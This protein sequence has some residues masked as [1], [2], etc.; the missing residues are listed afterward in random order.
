MNSPFDLYRA[1]LNGQVDVNNP[2]QVRTE[3]KLIPE[4]RTL[5]SLQEVLGQQITFDGDA[6]FVITRLSANSTGVFRFR[7]G[8]NEGHWYIGAGRNSGSSQNRVRS[9]NLFGTA[10]LP[11]LLPVPIVIPPNGNIIYDIQDISAA[12]NAIELAFVGYKIYAIQ[13]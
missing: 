9:E 5:T 7:L 12:E 1:Y 10:A 8:D 4:N 6:P 11:F 3:F 2:A 13:G